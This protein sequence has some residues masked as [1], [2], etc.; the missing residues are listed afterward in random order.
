MRK[1]APKIGVIVQEI[2]WF[3]RII[4]IFTIDS[5]GAKYAGA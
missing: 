1:Y 3:G 5:V 4:T 2:L